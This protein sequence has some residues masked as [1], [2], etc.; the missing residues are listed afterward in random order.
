[1]SKTI[2]ERIIAREIPA[3]IVYEDETICAFKDINPV[4]PVH[5]LV[6]PRKPIANLNA[7][8]A[9]DAAT[10]GHLLAKVREIAASLGLAEG[11]YRVVINTGPDAGEAEHHLHCHLLGGRPFGW[12]PG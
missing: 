6:V 2:F 5:V 12:P 4:A 7:V 11:G 10:L 3:Q 1:M 9:G 8:T